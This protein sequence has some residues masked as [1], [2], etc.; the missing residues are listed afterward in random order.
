MNL[1]S[2]SWIAAVAVVIGLTNTAE[3][4]APT[5]HRNKIC[6][7]VVGGSLNGYAIGSCS[8]METVV[9]KK[10][11]A[12]CPE[13]SRCRVSAY[14]R[15]GIGDSEDEHEPPARTFFIKKAHSVRRL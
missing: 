11:L 1:F 2:W 7:G 8:F 5:H 14:G 6:V 4:R 13:G 9:T 10:L 15:W 3:A 12:V